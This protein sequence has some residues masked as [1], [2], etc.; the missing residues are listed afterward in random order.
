MDKSQKFFSLEGVEKL[1]LAHAQVQTLRFEYC[2]R[3]GD[4]AIQ[5][6]AET[7]KSHLRA[8]AVVRDFWEASATISNKSLTS[9]AQNCPNL[10]QLHIHHS[11]EFES[12]NM[13]TGLS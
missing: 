5:L 8:L 2:T 6:I 11:R 1:C 10:T 12:V 3:I 9:L 13:L 7:N 4:E